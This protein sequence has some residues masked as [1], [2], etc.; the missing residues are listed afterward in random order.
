MKVEKITPWVPVLIMAG[1]FIFLIG[2]W[3]MMSRQIAEQHSTL[4][5]PQPVP[6]GVKKDDG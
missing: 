1:Y 2:T 6:E 4:Q 3:A 5:V